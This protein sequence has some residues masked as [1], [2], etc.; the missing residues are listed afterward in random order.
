M[1]FSDNIPYLQ[2]G[3]THAL[4]CPGRH[5]G[6]LCMKRLLSLLLASSLSWPALA[7]D[8]TQ[9]APPVRQPSE[10]VSQVRLRAGELP[11]VKL[12]A[13]ILYR[14]LA[15]EIAAQRGYYELASTTLLDLSGDTQDPRLAKRA[16]Q[17]AMADR[18][19][20]RAQS[21]AQRWSR[22]SPEDQD[23]SAAVLALAASNGQTDGL[24]AALAQR[25]AQAEDKAQAI[26]QAAAVAGRLRDK[27][28]ALRVLEK[29]LLPAQQ[30]NSV[31]HLALSDTAWAARDPERAIREARQALQ[32]DPASEDAAQRVLEYGQATDP[33]AALADTRR[34]LQAYPQAR[35]VQLALV[36]RLA[37]RGSVDEALQRVQD[38]L[39]R[40]PEDFDLLYVQ[41]EVNL[42]AQRYDQARALLDEYISVQTQRRQGVQHDDASD[43]LAGVSDAR[44]L[45]VQIAEK[46][47]NLDEA[48]AHLARIDEPSLVF[49]ARI[50]LAVLQGRQGNIQQAR[51]TIQG[52][53]PQDDRERA[54]AALTLAAIYRDSGRTDNAVAVLE[55]AEAQLPDSIEVKYDLAMLYERQGKDKAFESR[56]ERILELAPDNANANNALGYIFVDQNRRLDDAQVLLERAERLEPDNPFILDSVGWYHY[57]RGNLTLALEY[58]RRSYAA[59]PAADV[60]AHL[61]EVLWKLDRKDEARAIWREGLQREADNDTLRR[62]LQRLGVDRP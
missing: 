43:A 3:G 48:I 51:A 16:F 54:V 57:R 26:A 6:F 11:A 15:S 28:A 50:H 52:L 4:A 19:I 1:E 45:L 7:A 25:I 23:A 40:N 8:A 33:D 14:I 37:A 27:R 31:A 55:E 61:G 22:L 20:A 35:G 5:A 42:R 58:L 2:S 49:Q 60:A 34:Y 46:Q 56:M 21:A 32:L 24:S 13:D 29:A 12:T 9:P 36:S 62:T 18:N 47:G 41:A 44:L 38:M 10:Q 17:F 59:M 53:T 30:G 39:V